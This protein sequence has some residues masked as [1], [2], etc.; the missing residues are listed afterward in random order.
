MDARFTISRK[1]TAFE[2]L[3]IVR[4]LTPA[5]PLVDVL[6]KKSNE[7]QDKKVL[8]AMLLGRIS[9]EDNEHIVNKC[10]G[11]VSVRDGAALFPLMKGAALMYHDI[12][13]TDILDIVAEVIEENMGNFFR[14]ALTDS[15][16]P[17]G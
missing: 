17:E 16:Q 1:L 14:I 7:A 4:R 10:L 5:L 11:A 3:A 15:S 13:M 12:E 2:Q 6:L 9:D 8:V